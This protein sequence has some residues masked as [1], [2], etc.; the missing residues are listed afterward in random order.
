MLSFCVAGSISLTLSANQPCQSCLPSVI[1]QPSRI[2]NFGFRSDA[3]AN[4]LQ[5]ADAVRGFAA[6]SAEVK[7]GG[8]GPDDGDGLEL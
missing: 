6:V 4:A 8:I 3:V 5:N 2:D 1:W 7:V